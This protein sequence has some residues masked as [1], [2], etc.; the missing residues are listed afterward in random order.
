MNNISKLTLAL[1]A[2]SLIATFS[3]SCASPTSVGNYKPSG[4]T[5]TRAVM[6]GNQPRSGGGYDGNTT[7]TSQIIGRHRGGAR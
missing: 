5:S 1:F 4:P 6:R 7:T 2:G 3:C